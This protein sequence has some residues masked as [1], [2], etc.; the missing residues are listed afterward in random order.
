[1]DLAGQSRVAF[2]AKFV[3]PDHIIFV[4][5][6]ALGRICIE[7]R[8]MMVFRMGQWVRFPR[9]SQVKSATG[10]VRYMHESYLELENTHPYSLA[11]HLYTINCMPPN[12]TQ[13]KTI[14]YSYIPIK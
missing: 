5:C 10:P 12:E 11:C 2:W 6:F 7:T 9:R 3:N 4:E 8:Y 1:M 13:V 14:E